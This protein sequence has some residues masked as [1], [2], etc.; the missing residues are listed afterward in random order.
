[1]LS[2]INL[3]IYTPYLLINNG[4]ININKGRIEDIGPMEKYI[5][6]EKSREVNLSGYIAIPGLI[7]THFHGSNGYDFMDGTEEA[8]KSI[9][10]SRLKEGVTGIYPTTVS[11]SFDRTKKA[12]ETFIKVKEEGFKKGARLLGIHLEGPYISIKKKGAQNEKYI[13]EIDIEEI[14]KFIKIGMGF[15]KMVSY[16]PELKDGEKLTAFL[17]EKDIRPSMA[18]TEAS[19]EDV[20][21][22]YIYGLRHATHLFNGMI[23]IHHREIGPVGSALLYDDFYV[24]VIADKIHLSSS[25]LKLLTK[26]KDPAYIIL[27]T[28]AIR[29]QGLKDGVYELGGQEVFVKEKR[30]RLANGALAGST[31]FLNE[32]IK[33]L[34]EETELPIEKIIAMAT[35][36]P[37]KFMGIDNL[38]GSIE[39]GK[40]ADIVIADNNF[41][42]YKV[43]KEGEV[44]FERG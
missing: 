23:P 31:L 39:P 9:A 38:F 32:A 35:I 20:K 6:K 13:R 19:H 26:I 7:D 28:D 25:M 29:A 44:V 15:I 12:I 27:I 18:H 30:A 3:K 40:I 4:F 21:K 8:L 33:N 10:I 16:A 22:C 42:I 17:I 14:K 36:I 11:E 34:Q 2:L 41:N 24:E 1:M 37:A 5:H 43:Y